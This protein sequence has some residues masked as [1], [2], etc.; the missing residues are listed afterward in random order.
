[1]LNIEPDQTNKDNLMATLI[2]SRSFKRNKLQWVTFYSSSI[3]T[4]LMFI[5]LCSISAW[6]LSIAHQ[7]NGVVTKSTEILSDVDE[8][9]PILNAICDH[10][11]F[12]KRYGHICSIK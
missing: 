12:T 1:M 5:I 7:I 9:L 6:T 2:E 11:N 8:M 4:A 10:E 3:A